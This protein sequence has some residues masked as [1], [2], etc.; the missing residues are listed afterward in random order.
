ML[1]HGDLC[2][3][4]GGFALAARMAGGIDTRWFV[5]IE[6][7]CQRVLAKHWPGV[8]IYDDLRT[9]DLS[10]IEPV[11]LLTAGFPCQPVSNA[12]KRLGE[13]DPR[14]LWPHVARCIRGLRPR[15][16]LLENVPQLR[17]RGMGSVVGSLAA[18]GYDC[19]WDCIPASAVGAP[20]QRD[21]IW[22]VA[23][24]QRSRRNTRAGCAQSP[25]QRWPE[26]LVCGVAAG[27]GREWPAEPAIS[28]VASGLPGSVDRNRALGN[29]IV[30]QV[31]ELI[32]RRIVAAD[33]A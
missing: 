25:A 3:G 29:S 9:L 33:A 8:P 27:T 16:V 13:A 6:P 10:G 30:P 32:L 1:R 28:R 18:C 4:I 12:G 15:W 5:E 14:W 26:P 24:P 20:Q 23:Y 7:F 17:N 31:A 19:E 22:I 11:D 2:S 21:R